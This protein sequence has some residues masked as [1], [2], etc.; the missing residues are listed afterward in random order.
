MRASQLMAV[1]LAVSLAVPLAATAGHQAGPPVEKAL[2][3]LR[4]LQGPDGCIVGPNPFGPQSTADSAWSAVAFARAGIDPDTVRLP[5]GADLEAC[6]IAHTLPTLSLLSLERQVLALA[7]AGADPRTAPGFDAVRAVR[8]AFDGAQLGSPNLVNDDIFGLLALHA[9]GVPDTDPLVQAVRAFVLQNQQPTGA[10]GFGSI[11]PQ[12]PFLPFTLLFA[13]QDTT[14]AAV[15]ALL[16]TGSRSDEPAILRAQAW[17]K[18][19]QGLDGGC[20]W[21]RAGLATDAAFT[22]LGFIFW[23]AFDLAGLAA[24]ATSDPQGFTQIL[25][26]GATGAVHSNADST[27]WT[28]MAVTALGQD[29]AAGA[30]LVPP[31]QSL[32]SYLLGLQQPDGSFLWKA[33]APLAPPN[34]GYAPVWTTAWAVTALSGHTLV[35]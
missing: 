34:P 31:G 24:Y 20:T 2:G 16:A 28:I 22:G 27:S 26:S 4:S 3:Y 23:A 10:W 15:Q 14:A 11:Q 12:S 13:D 30:W 19:N 35:A 33:P 7:A 1:F 29:P 8:A 9:A 6:V 21:S 32:V 18:L 25:A 17:L 5:G